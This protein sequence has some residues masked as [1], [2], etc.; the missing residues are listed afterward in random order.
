M[1]WRELKVFLLHLPRDS[2]TYRSVFG[3][4][5]EWTP[6]THVLANLFDAVTSA[7]TPKGERH[8]PHPRP[9]L[10]DDVADN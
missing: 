5:A 6:T 9:V 3:E 7:L 8:T 10:P 1:T 2:A 4:A